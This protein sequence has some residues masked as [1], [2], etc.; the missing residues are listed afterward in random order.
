[1][2]KHSWLKLNKLIEL[3]Q[4][5]LRNRVVAVFGPEIRLVISCVDN[6]RM[7]HRLRLIPTIVFGE[8]MKATKE[9]EPSLIEFF[10]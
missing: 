7:I 9:K 1:M 5:R 4:F 8:P 10:E 2:N 3:F 6:L